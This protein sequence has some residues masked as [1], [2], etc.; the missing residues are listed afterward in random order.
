M[1]HRYIKDFDNTNNDL[2]FCE[3]CKAER[4]NSHF[5]VKANFMRISGIG[6]IYF[7][8]CK[9]CSA[10]LISDIEWNGIVMRMQIEDEERWFQF[11]DHGAT[12]ISAEITNC[13]KPMHDLDCNHEF[14]IIYTKEKEES[15]Y[16]KKVLENSYRRQYLQ[17]DFINKTGFPIPTLKEFT[18]NFRTGF[19]VSRCKKCGFSDLKFIYKDLNMNLKQNS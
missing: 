1:C 11:V 15:F 5:W 4:A 8:R 13:K 19:S 10:F 16:T 7:T 14:E 6:D 12:E 2:I 18:S 3:S 17:D 9:H